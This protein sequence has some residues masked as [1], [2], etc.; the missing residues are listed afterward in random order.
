L[1]E[2]LHTHN[3]TV[4]VGYGT[5]GF[6]L[7]ELQQRGIA[8]HQF[9]NLARSFN[10]L[11]AL[12]FTRELTSFI[13]TTAFD[14]VHFNSSNTFLGI[15]GLRNLPN[16]PCTIATMHGLSIVAPEHTSVFKKIFS[17]LFAFLLPKFDS[18][19]YISERDRINAEKA[20]FP[21]GNM[22]PL[23]IQKPQFLLKAEARQK[24]AGNNTLQPDDFVIGAV[25]RLAYPKNMAFLI[26]EFSTIKKIVPTAKLAIIGEGPE[27]AMLE[28][29]IRDTQYTTDITLCGAI[30]HAETL[31]R[32]FDMLIIPSTYEGV[33]YVALEALAAELP[34]LFSDVGGLPELVP[35]QFLFS[36]KRKN[37]E[38]QFTALAHQ[39]F[40]TPTLHK[41]YT[42]T[43]MAEEY[44][45]LY[46]KNYN[47]TIH[48][49]QETR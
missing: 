11:R 46:Q 6:L 39:N 28:Q 12:A 4:T 21:H 38:Q 42:L 7:Q 23:G 1:A 14:C 8:T 32:G 15:L 18:V 5:P 3:H 37:F 40:P 49:N 45:R 2:Y 48:R 22:I 13:Q 30:P 20:H 10:P 33:P 31:F 29:K 36:I 9:K 19:V 16:R 27:R 35:P 26:E 34:V 47:T 24:L 44:L 41:E 43:S 17:A 25:G